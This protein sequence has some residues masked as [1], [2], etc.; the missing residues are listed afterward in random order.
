MMMMVMMVMMVEEEEDH[1]QHQHWDQ[2]QDQD[3]E[4]GRNRT[5]FNTHFQVQTWETSTDHHRSLRSESPR[6]ISSKI[7]A[8]SCSSML[9]QP[10]MVDRFEIKTMDFPTDHTGGRHLPDVSSNSSGPEWPVAPWGMGKNNK[11]TRLVPRVTS[12]SW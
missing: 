9:R 2:D 5:H 1:D 3:D 4:S 10:L 7:D 12:N 11:P 8:A 6:S